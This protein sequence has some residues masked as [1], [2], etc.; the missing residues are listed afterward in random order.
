MTPS[1]ALALRLLRVFSVAVLARHCG[2][3]FSVGMVIYHPEWL[4]VVHSTSHVASVVPN[5]QV[6]CCLF[7]VHG[8][9][10]SS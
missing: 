8:I 9:N 2:V 7:R 1:D 3:V 6:T 4:P 10:L 5:Y